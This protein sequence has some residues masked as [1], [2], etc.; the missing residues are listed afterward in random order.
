MAA[1]QVEFS[2][3]YKI[4]FKIDAFLWKYG[5]KPRHCKG[6]AGLEMPSYLWSRK[7]G[8]LAQGTEDK[9]LWNAIL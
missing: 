1:L 9:V 7:V 5:G 3:K 8:S 2:E 4:G 6:P